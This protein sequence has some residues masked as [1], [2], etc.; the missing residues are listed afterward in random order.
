MT[1]TTRADATAPPSPDHGRAAVGRGPH[2]AGPVLVLLGMAA[3]WV[4]F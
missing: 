1:T 4:V 3:V 2:L